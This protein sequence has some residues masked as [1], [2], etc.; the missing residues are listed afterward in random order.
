MVHPAPGPPDR[1]RAAVGLYRRSDPGR[2]RHK[3]GQSPD[4]HGVDDNGRVRDAWID[5]FIRGDPA[6]GPTFTIGQD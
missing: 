6:A 1:G 3:P 5:W 2:L 4:E